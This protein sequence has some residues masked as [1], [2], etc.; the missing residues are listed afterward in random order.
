MIQLLWT[1]V[2]QFLKKL[3]MGLLH[4]PAIS[5][6]GIY[7]REWKA[8]SRRDTVQAC[9]WVKRMISL[10]IQ[11]IK[12]DLSR[13]RKFKHLNISR[14]KKKSIKEINT[15]KP[16]MSSLKRIRFKN[17][18]TRAWGKK[19]KRK[20]YKLFLWGPCDISDSAE[21][22][23]THTHT[24]NKRTWNNLKQYPTAHYKIHTL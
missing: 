1:T 14:G 21:K 8:G 11:F 15:K 18:E 13:D 10:K 23:Y 24:A 20:T 9:S 19:K 22:D 16:N 2:W 17:A 12:T 6:W 3:K 5:F 4:T 7:M